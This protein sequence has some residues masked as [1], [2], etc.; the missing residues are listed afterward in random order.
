MCTEKIYVKQQE[1]RIKRSLCSEMVEDKRERDTKE[2]V[3]EKSE[4]VMLRKGM[5]N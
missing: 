1:R 2:N 4:K 5:A 3:T